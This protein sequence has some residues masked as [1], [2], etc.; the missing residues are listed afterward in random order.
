MTTLRYPHLKIIADNYKQIGCR[1]FY[2]I[3]DSEQVEIS[4][5]VSEVKTVWVPGEPT[6]ATLQVPMPVLREST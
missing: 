4:D 1:V 6:M 2:V 3:N 5:V